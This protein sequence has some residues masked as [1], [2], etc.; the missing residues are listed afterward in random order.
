[1]FVEFKL[2]KAW[3]AGFRNGN[4][5][6]LKHERIDFNKQCKIIKLFLKI[7]VNDVAVFSHSLFYLIMNRLDLPEY[8]ETD[9]LRLKRLRYE[10]AEEIFFTYASKTDATRF[11]SW[12]THRTVGDTRSYLRFVV[13]AWDAGKDYTYGLRLRQNGK[14]VG[15]IGAINDQGEI[16]FGY[17]LSPTYWGKGFATEACK[18]LLSV[19]LKVPAVKRIHTFVDLENLASIQVLIKSGLKEE[20][21]LNKW[22]VFPNQGGV[23]KDC[24]VFQLPMPKPSA[25]ATTTEDS[26]GSVSSRVI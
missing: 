14:L 22:F 4:L 19:L 18:A 6:T 8:F 20:A 9:R 2:T 25:Y 24:M 1:M 15:S 7:L 13:P 16:Q 21:L 11:V 17:I 5:Q 10:D 3:I 26:T 12:P 23:Q